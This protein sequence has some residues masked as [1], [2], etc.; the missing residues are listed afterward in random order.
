MA[1]QALEFSIIGTIVNDKSCQFLGIQKISEPIVF[2]DSAAQ[3]AYKHILSMFVNQI[4]I[5][6]FSFQEYLKKQRAMTKIGGDAVFKSIIQHNIGLPNFEQ[7]L[8]MLNESYV[9]R[10]QLEVGKQIM[11][12]ATEK[13]TDPI[14]L[15]QTAITLIEKSLVG[16]K[17]ENTKSIGQE[18]DRLSKLMSKSTAVNET[19]GVTTGYEELDKFSKLKDGH[20]ILIA[21][22]PSMGKCLSAETEILMYDGKIK[23]ACDIIQGDILMG[24]D[25]TPRKVL[26]IGKGKEM[27]YWIKQFHGIDYRVNESHILSLKKSRKENKGDDIVN[28]SVKD[29]LSKSFKWKTSYKGYKRAVEFSEKEILL[30]PYLFGIWLGD[31]NSSDSRITNPDLE[32]FNYCEK[33][34][35]NRGGYVYISKS[36]QKDKCIQYNITGFGAKKS[37]K[38]TLRLMGVL[39]NKHIPINYLTN[40]KHIRLQLLA[41]LID[42]DGYVNQKQGHT[43][44][45]CAKSETLA[46]NIK[47]LCDSLGYRTSIRKKVGTIKSR[48]F[49]ATYWVVCFN[50]NTN[51]IPVLLERKKAKIWSDGRDW[52]NTGITVVKDKV[53]YYYGFELD[54]NH[55]FCLSDCTVTHN[56]AFVLEI[57]KRL[58]LLKKEPTAIFSL[59]M[60]SI[61]LVK[62]VASNYCK[63]NSY[64]FDGKF[65]YQPDEEKFENFCR[66]FSTSPFYIDDDSY[67]TTN[68]IIARIIYLYQTKKIKRFAIDHLGLIQLVYANKNTTKT[69]ALGDLSSALKR[70]ARKLKI[71]I[72]GLYQL[73]REVERRTPPRPILSDLTGSGSLEAD[74]D[75]VYLLYRPD[76][77]IANKF[78]PLKK[79]NLEHLRGKYVAQFRVNGALEYIDMEG[80]CELIIAKC[81]GGKTGRMFFDFDGRYGQFKVNERLTSLVNKK[82]EKDNTATLDLPPSKAEFEMEMK[83]NETEGF[84]KYEEQQDVF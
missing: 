66:T 45:I 36:K 77:Y 10:I 2:E 21:A 24:D 8:V 26:S 47:F 7:R 1:E 68:Q 13:A 34:A 60:E 30:D 48:N 55:L 25:S 84:E 53:D 9:Y 62:R 43:T 14:Q 16:D 57:L 18:L 20:F 59:E 79:D 3:L 63:I 83:A 39:Q 38:N 37:I 54:G 70:L 17:I 41:G 71:T 52:R 19:E 78:N 81:R 73:N 74:A 40:N 15:A 69:D 4:E 5:D 44:E 80:V 64:V 50:G 12:E 33:Y 42:S 29:Y 22:R 49:S 35:K 51:E 67:V 6:A 72:I 58:S 61:D 28:I 75:I 11:E 65:N 27:M 32:I 82:P 56:T 31:G 76:Y 46:R 23:K